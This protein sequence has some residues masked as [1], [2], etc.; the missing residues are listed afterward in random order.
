MTNREAPRPNQEPGSIDDL[1]VIEVISIDQLPDEDRQRFAEELAPARI[2]PI[3]QLTDVES[4]PGE[5]GEG[6][7]LIVKFGPV[8][9]AEQGRERPERPEVAPYPSDEH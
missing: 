5:D 4:I 8:S 3:G 6:D 9:P 2:A 1:P 7:T